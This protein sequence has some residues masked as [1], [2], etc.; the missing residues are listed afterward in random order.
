MESQPDAVTPGGA[1]SSTLPAPD[2]DAPTPEPPDEHEP[3]KGASAAS[4]KRRKRTRARRATPSAGVATPSEAGV[5]RAT[6]AA[7]RA[8]DR[9]PDRAADRDGVAPGEPTSSTAGPAAE[10]RAQVEAADVHEPGSAS[11]AIDDVTALVVPV[12]VD[13]APAEDLAHGR[14]PGAP[15]VEIPPAP[16]PSLF[17]PAEPAALFEPVVPA[18]PA[19]LFE[20]VVPAEPS[21]SFQLAAPPRMP[22]IDPGVRVRRVGVPPGVP[23]AADHA[24]A[25][26]AAADHAAA[27]HA[28]AEQAAEQAAADPVATELDVHEP[29]DLLG[30]TDLLRAEVAGIVLPLEVPGVDGARREHEALLGQIDDY[31][32]PRL[33]RLDAP[34]LAV[35]GGSTGAGKST[36]VNSIARREVTRSGVLRPTTRSPVLVHH[37]YDSGAF[38]SQRVLPGLARVTSEAPEPAQPIEVDA[39]RVTALRLVPHDGITPGL[40]IIDAPDIDSVVEANRDLAVQLLGSADLWVFVTTSVRYA[41]AVPWQ[42]L[43]QALDRGVAVAVV[44]DRVPAEVMQEVRTHLARLLRDRGLGTSPMFTI[45]ETSLESGYLPHELLAPLAGWLRRLALD[46]RSRDVVVRRT[47]I[48]VLDSLRE[49]VRIVAAAADTQAEAVAALRAEVEALHASARAELERSLVDGS[50]TRGEVLARWQE[51]VATGDVFRSLEPGGGRIVDRVRARVRGRSAPTQ[52]LLDAVH[53]GVENV[54]L[55]RMRSTSE[56][57]TAAWR[58]SPGGRALLAAAP[59]AAQVADDCDERLAR[60][61]REWRMALTDLAREQSVPDQAGTGALGQDGVVAALAVLAVSPGGDLEPRGPAVVGSAVLGALYGREVVDAL[62]A[63]ARADLAG[64]IRALT[65]GERERALGVLDAL[66][67]RP[68]S[69]QALLVRASVVEEAR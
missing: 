23:T 4:T 34:L 21:A 69:G 52:P 44:L 7:D 61:L 8:P 62:V 59:A 43:K 32:L 47:L 41:D 40:A 9:A 42:L 38:L 22:I 37:P 26:H 33:R 18:E 12:S 49:R 6:T 65:D 53:Q 60:A 13:A 46:A 29:H 20:P 31:L 50:V 28:A 45:P 5:R 10:E 51:F 63:A 67:I 14:Q 36:L 57:L 66:G 58:G 56:A 54:V 55:S 16:P 30:A 68:G 24:A 17:V 3:V 64:R 39:P 27:D 11:A 48:G 15:A 35:F 25:D 2:A 1:A 19:T